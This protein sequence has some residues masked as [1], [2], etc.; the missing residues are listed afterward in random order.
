VSDHRQTAKEEAEKIN[1]R[2]EVTIPTP[3]G[4]KNSRRADAAAK[5]NE[6]VTAVTQ[7]YR[8]TPAGKIPKRE[9]EAREDIENATGVK[10][11][12]VP[13]RPLN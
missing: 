5:V 10:P 9:K 12:M 1:G 11:K 7:M 13:V 2:Q 3:G 4:A 6:K 8:P